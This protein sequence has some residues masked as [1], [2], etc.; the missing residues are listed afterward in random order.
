M[1]ERKHQ[2]KPDQ[3]WLLKIYCHAFPVVE[4]GNEDECTEILLSHDG[5]SFKVCVEHVLGY[6]SSQD[7]SRLIAKV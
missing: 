6:D 3:R 2:K 7:M 4:F 1:S 5:S